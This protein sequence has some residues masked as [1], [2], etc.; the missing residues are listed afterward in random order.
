MT[1]IDR[2]QAWISAALLRGSNPKVWR[3]DRLGYPV[4]KRS[5]G[6]STRYGWRVVTRTDGG[7]GLGSVE[8]I[9]R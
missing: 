6:K 7:D 2:E 9:G 8:A 5:Y 4:Y 3:R 1:D